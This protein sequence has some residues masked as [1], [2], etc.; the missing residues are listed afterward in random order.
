MHIIAFY[1][2]FTDSPLHVDIS[3]LMYSSFHYLSLANFIIVKTKPEQTLEFFSQ[4][5][6]NLQEM[7]LN[8]FVFV[9]RG[10]NDQC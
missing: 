10:F 7:L 5:V 4:H 6:L 9:N 3:M 2:P 1:F 8:N